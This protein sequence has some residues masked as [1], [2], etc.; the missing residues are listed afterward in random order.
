MFLPSPWLQGPC[1]HRFGPG[2]APQCSV[3]VGSTS[4]AVSLLPSWLCS[5]Y[6]LCGCLPA[7]PVVVYLLTYT[8]GGAAPTPASQSTLASVWLTK[9]GFWKQ[10]VSEVPHE[11]P[12]SYGMTGQK[13]GLPTS[14]T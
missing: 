5:I 4:M 6:R 9:P 3:K 10:Q 7:A 8:Y 1:L 12:R 14:N 13:P 11:H 2:T